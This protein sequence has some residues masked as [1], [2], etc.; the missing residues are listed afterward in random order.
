M[1]RVAVL[2]QGTQNDLLAHAGALSDPGLDAHVAAHGMIPAVAAVLQAARD[3]GD[4]V[5]HAL[6]VVDE[7]LPDT[8]PLFVG[9]E[10]ASGVR[11]GS[12]GAAPI[13]EL[14]P[15]PGDVVLEK[16]RENPFLNTGL[17][18][19]LREND[20]RTVVLVGATTTMGVGHAARFGADAGLRMIV[21]SDA[22]ADVSTAAHEAAVR[23]GL[24]P[25]A[26]L[27]RVAEYLAGPL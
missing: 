9:I 5:V 21:L 27:A 19:L 22:T 26:T 1:S 7:P 25:V 17:D 20:V 6:F 16:R 4:L 11:R 3:R 24:P 8:A 13:P 23:F 10:A 14:A 12:W 2:V 18:D 15:A